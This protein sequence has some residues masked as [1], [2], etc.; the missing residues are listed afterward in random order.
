[1]FTAWNA[2]STRPTRDID[3]LARMNNSADTVLPIIREICSAQ[4]EPDGLVF[5]VNTLEAVLI[6][7]DADYE[8]L[9]V[10]F[11]ARLQNARVPMQLDLGFGDV[12]TPAPVL[13]D[14]PT[15]LDFA[16]PRLYGY[17]R[18]TAVA[19]KFEAM[20]KFG[21]LNSRMK[22][23]FDIQMLAR[24]FEFDGTTLATAIAK[25]FARRETALEIPPYAL[26]ESF[27]A[28]SVKIAQWNAFL[29]KSRITP[30]PGALAEVIAAIAAF[31]MAPAQAANESRTFSAQW[32]PPGPWKEK[33]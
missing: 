18:E 25:T 14:Y 12:L 11:L 20:V 30:S 4:V 6:K 24:Q 21:Q 3:F 28:D 16:P 33:L 22:D 29:R 31:L 27:A 13:T 17:S 32:T 5:D 15:I 10:T 2:P 19:E 26:T 1:M 7:E 8:G 9:R 23:F